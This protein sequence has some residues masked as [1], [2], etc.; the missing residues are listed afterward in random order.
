MTPQQI[1]L[2]RRIAVDERATVT[3]AAAHEQGNPALDWTNELVASLREHAR[4]TELSEQQT[5][6]DLP[7]GSGEP[8]HEAD[9]L[10][11]ERRFLEPANDEAYPR[12]RGGQRAAFFRVPATKPQLSSRPASRGWSKTGRIRVTSLSRSAHLRATGP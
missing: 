12:L 4:A 2:V 3:V 1:E 8:E 11:L 9:L 7:P 5:S 6:R 10:E